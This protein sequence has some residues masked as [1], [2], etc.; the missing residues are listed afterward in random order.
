M[1]VR[2]NSGWQPPKMTAI[3]YGPSP[4]T[5]RESAKL[6]K[7]QAI[8]AEPNLDMGKYDLHENTNSVIL[9]YDWAFCYV[10]IHCFPLIVKKGFVVSKRLAT[11]KSEWLFY[12]KIFIMGVRDNVV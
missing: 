12:S 5:D 1:G 4:P 3:R 11:Q 2:L 6:E 10:Y 8:L 7:F 9:L